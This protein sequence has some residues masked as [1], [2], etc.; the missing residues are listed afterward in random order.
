MRRVVITG[1]G[2]VTPLG[3]GVDENF[4]A[5][6]AGQSGIG[7]ITLFDSSALATHFA[8]E[9]KAFEPTRWIEKREVKTLDRFLHFAIAAGH[10]AIE[11]AGLPLKLEGEAA[12]RA[13]CYVGAGL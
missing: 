9:V 11:D 6:A 3:I 10:L 4:K 12:E 5:L 13:G 8:G 1:I 7:P 2:L